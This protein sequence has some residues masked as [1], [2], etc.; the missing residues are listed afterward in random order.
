MLLP[1]LLVATSG[2]P[3][4]EVRTIQ[5]AVHRGEP[6]A[7][8]GTKLLLR[9]AGGTVALECGDMLS[10]IAVQT[11]LRGSPPSSL[12]ELADGDLLYGS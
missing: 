5:D 8:E 6:S 2:A 11:P 3:V 9:T 1:F 10:A 7:L 12:L 4:F